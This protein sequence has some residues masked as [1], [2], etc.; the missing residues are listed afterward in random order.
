L[1]HGTDG[2]M[3]L[4]CPTCGKSDI[5][6]SVQYPVYGTGSRGQGRLGDHGSRDTILCNSCGC[7]G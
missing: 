5:T 1:V 4:A 2:E 6:M 3:H 7:K